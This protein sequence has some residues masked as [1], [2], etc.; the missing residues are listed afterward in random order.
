LNF[1]GNTKDEIFVQSGVKIQEASKGSSILTK[2]NITALEMYNKFPKLTCVDKSVKMDFSTILNKPFFCNN[3]T[4]ATGMPAYST[5]ANINFPTNAL[6]G[7]LATAPFYFSS[8]CRIRGCFNLQVS[9]TSMHQGLLLAAAVPADQVAI[10]INQLLCAP[11]VFLN[12]NEATPVCL[13]MPYYSPSN[14]IK[15]NSYN[16]DAYSAARADTCKLVI[17][18]LNPLATT[19]TGSTSLTVSVH[20]ELKEAEFYVPRGSDIAWTQAGRSFTSSLLS[21]PTK[22]FD[23]LTHGAKVITGDFIDTLRLGLRALTGFHNPNSTTIDHR[24]IVGTRNFLNNV[25][26]PTLFEKLSSHAKHDRV[27]QDYL[28][29]TSQDEM[30]MLHILQKP[31]FLGTFKVLS[32][33]TADTNLFN[34]PISPYVEVSPLPFQSNLR[35]FYELSK[36]WRGTIRMHIQSVMTPFHFCKLIVVKDYSCDKRALTQTPGLSNMHNMMTETIEFSAGGQIH[37]VD[38]PFCAITEQLECTKDLAV[39]ALQHGIVRIYLLQPLTSNA[40]VPT[41]VNFNVYYS[42]GDDFQYYGY[43]Q[44]PVI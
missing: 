38:L 19:A 14:L 35:T 31:V 41:T 17:A 36:Y 40:S 13:E 24:M 7:S 26:Q 32:T 11:H 29:C 5:V 20:I 27:A 44:D 25:D 12:A 8:L 23:G 28:F 9:G 33:T 2:S 30:D 16:W 15:T 21:I 34:Y 18:V 22:I 37:T 6:S 10:G 39:N 3:Y 43:S 1:L 42:V 4:W